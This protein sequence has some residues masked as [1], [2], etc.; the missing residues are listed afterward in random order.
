M[1]LFGEKVVN[2]LTNSSFN[3]LQ[4]ENFSEIF[5]DVY[6][7]E[8]NGVKYPVE[9][10]SEY[11]GNPVVSVPVVKG[12]QEIMFPFVLVKG[13][14][15]I[16]FN[17]N[18]VNSITDEKFSK[19]TVN[20]SVKIDDAI[21]DEIDN[22]ITTVINEEVS[23][24]EL[25]ESKAEILEQI[26]QAKENAKK[27][28]INLKRQKIEE[29][30]KEILENK[31]V[32]VRT[33]N[34]AKGEL[35]E[36]FLNI[37]KN[38]KKELIVENDNRFDEIKLTI[39]NKISDLSDT[40]LESLDKDLSNS[41]EQLDKQIRI[42][43]KEMHSSLTPIVDKELKVIA[44]D[45]V[46]KVVS[47]EKQLDEK[48]K[49]KADVILLENVEGELN[50]VA[51]ANIEL[52]D[53]IN[54]GVNKALSRVGNVDTKVN[55]LTIALSEEVENKI[56]KSEEN[57][58]NYYAEKLKML[59][60]K[61]FDITE[62][63]RKYIV[64]LVTESRNNLITEIRNTKNEKPIEYIVESKG[65]KKSI[66]SDD[67]VKDFDK[68]INF[69]IDNEVTRL[70]KY[71]SV[72]SGGG[73][74]AMQ[75]ADGGTMNGNLNVNGNI[76]I[77]GNYLINGVNI[78][79][80][81]SG[82]SSKIRPYAVY[83]LTW[84]VID[85]SQPWPHDIIDGFKVC[86]QYTNTGERGIFVMDGSGMLTLVEP[87]FD[88][89][90]DEST[91]TAYIQYD[92]SGVLTPITEGSIYSI[93]TS[94]NS[95]SLTPVGVAIN[96]SYITN[97]QNSYTTVQANS[98]ISWE[99]LPVG[100]TSGTV[101]AGDD[102]RFNALIASTSIWNYKAK[103]NSQSGNPTNGYILW[104]N[105]TQLSSTNIHVSHINDSNVDIERLLGS[106][107]I[108]QT[109]YIQD[110]DASEN[111]QT[112]IV[113][114][115][116]T[117]V[118]AN[119]PTAYFIFPVTLISSG[120]TGTTNFPNNHQIFLGL[121]QPITGTDPVR[122][123]LTGNGSL[124]TFA[125][126]GAGSLT[127]P[128][129]LTVAID[130]A[131][132][133]PVTDYSVASGNITFTSP[134]ESGAI[135][136]VISP[137]NTLQITEM[138]PA[139]GSVSS[140][141]LANDISISGTFGV[142]GNASFNSTTR[143]VAPNVTGTPLSSSLMT[144][145]DAINLIARDHNT[146]FINFSL[147]GT[148]TG[149]S[150][151]SSASQGI[152]QLFTSVTASSLAQVRYNTVIA[153][154]MAGSG[155]I[156]FDRR[157]ILRTRVANSALRSGL[158]FYFQLGRTN[159]VATAAQLSVKGFGFGIVGS[160]VTPFVH[161]GSTLTTTLA[162]GA[163]FSFVT[164]PNIILDF[165]PGVSLSVYGISI[166]SSTPVLLCTITAGLPSGLGISNNTQLEWLKYDT[167]SGGA[168]D[169]TYLGHSSITIL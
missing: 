162:T 135:A 114:G 19:A 115:T 3:I 86:I 125:I 138:I 113:S 48:L 156:D 35:V 98:A 39:D 118:G 25:S 76:N 68:K 22:I 95:C 146:H 33:L 159:A 50:A 116:P 165:V 13:K 137:T 53:K 104:N 74:V 140:T 99:N 2:S 70:R 120:G 29:A 91:I 126:S 145:N 78:T 56:S 108:N 77:T 141:K 149:A 100:N 94:L 75:F 54:K 143:P 147:G 105:S 124:S 168:N 92:S 46:D 112:W 20:H 55:E 167:G 63:T 67:L 6:E 80:S 1:K 16:I 43:V 44:T 131:L 119:T 151:T 18:N 15:N 93:Y 163:T 130:G 65:K 85:L 69:K 36:E 27:A 164:Y 71:I 66:N 4:V 24:A 73:S 38:I 152:W 169:W 30:N 132:Q 11:K 117:A 60:E 62:E 58:T 87:I 128:S 123:V 111:F 8:L 7:V 107:V 82:G 51:K 28:S 9:K 31:K 64:E 127:N 157:M 97:W 110:K 41:S 101:A 12:T 23:D 88:G 158:Q 81:L 79:S 154:S 47:I 129:A 153:C 83:A 121:P 160:T 10:I 102:P 61:T 144:Q 133:N 21:V 103:T 148:G 32:L 52:N 5:F 26:Q 109:I 106:I 139:D 57:I 37:S 72:Y 34:K 40:L 136:V 49:G 59:E 150:G 17:E 14:S 122:T 84:E 42:L 142:T 166:S 134:L 161:D 96:N 89:T 90:Y 155:S 45:I